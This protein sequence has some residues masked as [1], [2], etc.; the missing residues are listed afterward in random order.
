MGCEPALCSWPPLRLARLCREHGSV[1]V[2]M[3]APPP[4]SA[5]EQEVCM[6]YA[7]LDVHR[8]FCEAALVEEGQPRSGG[9][10]ATDPDALAQWARTLG[11]STIVALEATGNALA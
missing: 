7:A 4:L 1:V 5:P 3:P 2:V 6:R 9:R 10:I 8:D 11:P